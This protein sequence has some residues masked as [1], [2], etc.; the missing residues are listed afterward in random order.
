MANGLE[1]IST[2][3]RQLTD[4]LKLD[5]DNWEKKEN[6]STNVLRSS[7]DGATSERICCGKC[8]GECE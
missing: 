5:N 7:D 1:H 8:K 6:G 4:E 3:L 2:I